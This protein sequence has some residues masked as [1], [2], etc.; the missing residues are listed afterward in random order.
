MIAPP[1]PPPGILLKRKQ[2]YSLKKA[3]RNSKRLYYIANKMVGSVHIPRET[4]KM[5]AVKVDISRRTF[6]ARLVAG[7]TK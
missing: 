2:M 1:P 4:A 7:W 6:L 3:G 5:V